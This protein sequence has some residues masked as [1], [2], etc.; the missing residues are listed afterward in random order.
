M[1]SMTR[2]PSESL[3]VGRRKKVRPSGS[4]R[5]IPFTAAMPP[6]SELESPK[7]KI[8]TAGRAAGVL[9]PTVPSPAP[10]RPP[11]TARATATEPT[12]AAA[13]PRSPAAADKLEKP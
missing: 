10:S 11:P 6:V 4:T 12:R 2:R 8:T 5:F 3:P 1:K 9:P 13:P 7:L